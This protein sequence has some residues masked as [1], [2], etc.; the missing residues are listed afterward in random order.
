[1]NPFTPWRTTAPTS[2]DWYLVEC[3]AQRHWDGQAW[4]VAISEQCAPSKTP[5][6]RDPGAVVGL[7]WRSYSKRFLATVAQESAPAPSRPRTPA[8]YPG[9][10][11]ITWTGGACPVDG[12]ARVTAHL[13]SGERFSGQAGAFTW[14]HGG[15]PLDVTAYRKDFP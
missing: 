9:D 3:E 11:W 2:P 13:R 4:S 14:A 15:T 5:P 10:G 7:R 8:L 12:W 1:M 6:R